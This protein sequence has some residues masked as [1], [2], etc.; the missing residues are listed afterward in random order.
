MNNDLISRKALIETLE[1]FLDTIC[2]EYTKE[3][4]IAKIK[5]MPAVERDE[6]GTR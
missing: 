6:D 1:P 4:V 5:Y 3:M 2:S